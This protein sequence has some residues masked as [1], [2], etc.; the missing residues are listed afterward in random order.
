MFCITQG[1]IAEGNKKMEY[2][3]D[4]VGEG[5]LKKKVKEMFEERETRVRWALPVA[6][7]EHIEGINTGRWCWERAEEVDEKGLSGIS[8][9]IPAEAGR[10]RDEVTGRKGVSWSKGD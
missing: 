8:D 6:S 3:A 10:I 9:S 2:F 1:E 5:T 7:E 4:G